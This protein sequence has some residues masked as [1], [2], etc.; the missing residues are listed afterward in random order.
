MVQLNW[1]PPAPQ[2]FHAHPA[3]SPVSLHLPSYSFGP[4][5]TD[6]PVAV[7]YFN[8]GIQN[9]E[10]ARQTNNWHSKV[11]RLEADIQAAFNSV[12]GLQVLLLS[13]CG[14]MYKCIGSVFRDLGKSGGGSHPARN[15]Q[16]FFAHLLQR[17]D[18]AHIEVHA[19][20]P[21]LLSLTAR[22]GTSNFAVHSSRSVLNKI[23]SRSIYS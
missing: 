18:I 2:D 22:L 13:E 21:T 16:E 11:R 14:N 1:I 17:I 8:L 10:V 15:T 9:N 19:N 6:T 3:Q 5:R 20:F 23:P 4:H 7:A 12:H